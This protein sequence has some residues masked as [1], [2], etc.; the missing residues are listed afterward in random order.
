MNRI[1]LLVGV[2]LALAAC[3]PAAPA[4][5]SALV[6]A[7]TAYTTA[8]SRARSPDDLAHL[9]EARMAID[10]AEAVHEDAPKSAAARDASYVALR[11]TQAALAWSVTNVASDRT[12]AFE[13]LGERV[14]DE[15]EAREEGGARAKSAPREVGRSLHDADTQRALEDVGSL[16]T[17]G[18]DVIVA[19]PISRLFDGTRTKLS[20]AGRGRLDR[21]A[22]VLRASRGQSVTVVVASG[23]A[24][25]DGRKAERDGDRG[26]AV[27]SYL[28]SKGLN[29]DV[30]GW[31]AERRSPG[32]PSVVRI[33]IDTGAP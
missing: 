29:P 19:I 24:P 9:L 4:P 17:K 32:A 8:Q 28:T 25:V 26:D 21:V 13:A 12:A 5:G 10:K 27:A 22:D 1:A 20:S 7:R 31:R 11:K 33:E 18:R 30:V 2:A 16:R 3:A 14:T 23:D 6:E 15:E